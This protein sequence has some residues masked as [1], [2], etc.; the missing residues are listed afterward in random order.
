MSCYNRCEEENDVLKGNFHAKQFWTF[1]L[2]DICIYQSSL[3]FCLCCERIL[4][5]SVYTDCHLYIYLTFVHY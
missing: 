4:V 2:V 3:A 1:Y 5:C